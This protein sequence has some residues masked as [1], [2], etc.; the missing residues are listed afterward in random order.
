MLSLSGYII[1]LFEPKNKPFSCQQPVI[2]V[3]DQI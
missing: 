2:D 3:K 1:Y